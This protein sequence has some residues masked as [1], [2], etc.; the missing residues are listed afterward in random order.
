MAEAWRGVLWNR[1]VRWVS[2]EGFKRRVV[3]GRVG[4]WAGEWTEEGK[5]KGDARWEPGIGCLIN[6]MQVLREN[7]WA[8]V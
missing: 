6:E 5:G 7:G 1:A 3:R 4:K 8:H 2:T